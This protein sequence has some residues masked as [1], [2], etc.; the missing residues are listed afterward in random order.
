MKKN[1]KNKKL[2]KT[3]TVDNTLKKNISTKNALLI[4]GAVL[5][6]HYMKHYFN[7]KFP[8]KKENGLYVRVFKN[9]KDRKG[10]IFLNKKQVREINNLLNAKKAINEEI[11]KIKKSK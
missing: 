9:D 4:G 11:K 6:L 8:F 7:N 10:L 1:T 2:G 3:P 5:T